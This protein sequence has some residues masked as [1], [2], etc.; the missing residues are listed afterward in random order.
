MKKFLF[1]ASM[2]FLTTLTSLAQGVKFHLTPDFKFVADDG[3]EFIVVPMNGYSQDSLFNNM[4]TYL[5]R[6]YPEPYNDIKKS[7]N[8]TQIIVNVFL[9]KA[10]TDKALGISLF[11]DILCTYSFEFKDN[12]IKINQPTAYPTVNGINNLTKLEVSCAKF[13][14]DGKINPKKEKAYYDMNASINNELNKIL[15]NAFSK[16]EDW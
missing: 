15:T 1:I 11:I 9:K 12:K 16:E 7:K 8:N 2:L 5:D 4:E 3:K 10:Y 14:K 6:T 13:F